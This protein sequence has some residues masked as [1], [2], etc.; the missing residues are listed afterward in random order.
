MEIAESLS[1]LKDR[2]WW[3]IQ[4]GKEKWLNYFL[5]NGLCYFVCQLNSVL[6]IEHPVLF[7]LWPSTSIYFSLNDQPCQ[8]SLAISKKRNLNHNVGWWLNKPRFN[9]S[10]EQWPIG[11][12]DSRWG[13]MNSI[14]VCTYLNIKI[15]LF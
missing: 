3:D 11:S 2:V 13:D 9:L 4:F 15:V 5:L 10:L 12:L 1:F 8:M 7:C 14:L 6:I